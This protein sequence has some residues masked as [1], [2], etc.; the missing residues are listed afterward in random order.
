MLMPWALESASSAPLSRSP[1]P[2]RM[3][4]WC[5]YAVSLSSAGRKAD[6]QNSSLQVWP[7]TILYDLNP[8]NESSFREKASRLLWRGSPD[9]VGVDPNLK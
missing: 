7:A 8:K 4:T 1:K 3:G 5:V 9:G 2:R 6:A